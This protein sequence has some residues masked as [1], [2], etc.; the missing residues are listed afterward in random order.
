MQLVTLGWSQCSLTIPKLLAPFRTMLNPF[1]LCSGNE[2][3]E[4]GW[5]HFCLQH[6]L[7]NIFLFILRETEMKREHKQ[8]RGT[9]RKR[10]RI[11][12]RLCNVSTEPDV[13]LE[14]MN[15]KIMTWAKTKSQS[16]NWLSHPG[17]PIFERLLSLK[18]FQSKKLKQNDNNKIKAKSQPSLPLR[19]HFIVVTSSLPL[20]TTMLHETLTLNLSSPGKLESG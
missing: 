19:D 6:G 16:L 2:T 13:R 11:P 10:E 7:L 9:E 18:L 8:R 12:S 20:S 14:L 3:T 1:C 4:P 17:A 5:Q 15:F